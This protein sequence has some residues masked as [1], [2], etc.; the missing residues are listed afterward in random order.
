MA[1]NGLEKPKKQQQLRAMM[2]IF[3]LGKSLCAGGCAA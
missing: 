2:V 1:F 3:F